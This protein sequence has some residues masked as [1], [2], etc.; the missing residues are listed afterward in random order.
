LKVVG[1]G[2]FGVVRQ[3][4]SLL[5]GQI[6]AIKTI[7]LGDTKTSEST[8]MHEVEI[9]KELNHPNIIEYR[10]YF[11]GLDFGVR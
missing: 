4:K 7:P 1:R 10:G 6:Y 3:C 9:I 2:S 5:D 11:T 8:R